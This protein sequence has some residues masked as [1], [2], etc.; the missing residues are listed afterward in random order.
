MIALGTLALL[1]FIAAACGGSSS[2][3]MS[4]D[5]YFDELEQLDQSFSDR[6]DELDEEYADDLDVEEFSEEAR[7]SFASYFDET[8]AAAGDFAEELDGLEPPS[9]VEDAHNTAVEQFNTCLDETEDVSGQID[10]AES[11]E[12]ISAIL[13]ES[14]SSC[15]D[16]TASCEALQQVAD[17]NDIDVSLTCGE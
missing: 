5:E 4:L 17:E 8:R 2:D 16:T 1:T 11:F 3:A 10:E 7:G 12:D 15:E 13:T 9:D 14:T 6:Q